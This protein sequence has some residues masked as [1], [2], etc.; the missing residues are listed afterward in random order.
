MGI[1][2]RI[3]SH[4]LVHVTLAPAVGII[5]GDCGNFRRWGLTGGCGLLETALGYSPTPFQSEF[6]LC[7]LVS[8]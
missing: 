1:Q 3:V 8:Q 7:L 5:W 4:R 6:H 2:V